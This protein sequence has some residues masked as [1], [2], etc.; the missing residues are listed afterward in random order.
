MI[1]NDSVLIRLQSDTC[2]QCVFER[3]QVLPAD[4]GKLA[5]EIEHVQRRRAVHV[6]ERV[7]DKEFLAHDDDLRNIAGCV[8]W[9]LIG[10]QGG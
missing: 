3:G 7:G 9:G 8:S 1:G 2:L 6:D 5:F 4:D 10:K